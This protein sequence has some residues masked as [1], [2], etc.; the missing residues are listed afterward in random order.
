MRYSVDA[1]LPRRLKNWLIEQ[2]RVDALHTLDLP[3]R[4]LT[5][6]REIIDQYA[7]TDVVVI[8]KD[9][10]FPQQRLLRGKPERLLWVTTGNIVNQELLRLFSVNFAFIDEAFRT[11]GQF[12]EL[13]N[14]S[15]IIHE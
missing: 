11:G 2:G 14:V 5:P 6:D 1:Q 7:S 9:R 8:S 10:D 12:I 4:N 15:V 3:K 13:D